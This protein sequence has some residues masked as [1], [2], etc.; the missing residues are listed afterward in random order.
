MSLAN[1]NGWRAWRWA[2]LAVIAAVLCAHA[3]EIAGV[4]TCNPLYAANGLLTH[5]AVHL[6]PGT[7]RIDSNDGTTVQALGGR[8]A[9]MWL[10]LRLPW[11]NSDAG[12][13]LPLA[14]EGQP[15]AFFLPFVL[16]L[17]FVS[18]IVLLKLAL[19]ILAGAAAVALCR[20]LG[21]A[22]AAAAV[23]GILFALNGSFAWYAHSPVLPIPFLPALLFG[24]ERSRRRAA[25]GLPGGPLWIALALG[26]SLVA[27]FPETAFMDGL[28]AALWAALALLRLRRGAWLKFALKVAAGGLAGLALAAP[29]WVSFADYLGISSVGLH[30]LVIGDRLEPSQ[31]VTLLLPGIYGPP[32]ADWVLFAWG[33]D[34]GFFGPALALLALLGL[35]WRR[36]HAALRWAMAGWIAF[37]LS[38]FY[39][40]PP[41]HAVWAAFR[42]LNEVQV[43]R[44]AFPSLECAAAVLA[45]FAVDD[46]RRARPLR[47]RGAALALLGLVLGCVAL[48]VPIHRLP[49]QSTTAW[50]YAGM[51]V[52][53]AVLAA[54]ALI[55]LLRAPASR[56]R[57]LAL[58][59]VVALD[60]GLN[61]AL[62]EFAGVRPG[63]LALAPVK[64]LRANAGA[65]RVFAL[66]EALPT[67]YGSWFGVPQIQA[68]SIPFSSAWDA[69][70]VALG[71]DV[72]MANTSWLMITPASQLAAFRAAAAKLRQGG[73]RYVVVEAAHDPFVARPE[74]G[75]SVA[76]QN[77]RVRIYELTQP[78]PYF[79]I[80]SGGPCRLDIASREHVATSCDAPALLLRHELLLPGWRARLNGGKAPISAPENPAQ[81]GIDGLLQA[82]AVPAGKADI[83]FRYAPPHVALMAWLFGIG[84]VSLLAMLRIEW[85]AAQRGGPAETEI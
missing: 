70:A 8:A 22:R 80:A 9:D 33:Q 61:F 42:P 24:L 6:L 40:L 7:C 11:W 38:V 23:G 15:P 54:G 66:N 60:A 12:L 56:R 52:A 5:D 65:S 27:G 68:D 82:V 47:L 2:Y 43:T 34:G 63:K 44:Y 26:Y 81:G 67:N 75:M 49:P 73:V 57:A 51:A 1:R 58:A 31:A 46:W 74:P 41:T 3:P 16:L 71:G 13:G 50:V 17:H 39:G 85:R 48:A 62:P 83:R 53:E 64:F 59:T 55:W 29:A 35:A 19:Q 45:A 10:H 77:G 76:Y 32:F 84:L 72:N 25:A 36:P 28:L 37:W 4:V 69:A 78:A 79:S 20:E 14:A 18:G 21:L 30:A